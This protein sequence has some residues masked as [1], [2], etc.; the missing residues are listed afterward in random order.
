MTAHGPA[1]AVAIGA[2]QEEDVRKD[3][4]VK[5]LR[6]R[7]GNHIRNEAEKWAR[8]RRHQVEPIQLRG[9][10]HLSKKIEHRSQPVQRGHSVNRLTAMIVLLA[11]LVPAIVLA[12]TGI[13]TYCFRGGSPI[14]ND[15]IWAARSEGQGLEWS[16]CVAAYTGWQAWY[17]EDDN[18]VR[19]GAP[20]ISNPKVELPTGYWYSFV[21]KH[22]RGGN[23]GF[24]YSNWS[25][26]YHY[27]DPGSF[28]V[29]S[30]D[31]S[32]DSAPA[33]PQW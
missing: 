11:C 33:G 10:V 6:M 15:T 18:A 19:W 12:D 16:F 1:S 28:K 22:P 5:R 30:L 20:S 2:R 27:T 29:D 25:P 14:T 32:R 4:E 23:L 26:P 13:Y 21:A 8:T 24:Y 31:L 7:G 9:W 17:F 3:T